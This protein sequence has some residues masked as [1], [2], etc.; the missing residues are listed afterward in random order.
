MVTAALS[1]KER[2]IAD[3]AEFERN[4]IWA[5][6]N[7]D[8]LQEYLDQYIAVLDQKM[9]GFSDDPNELYRRFGDRRDVHISWVGPPDLLWVL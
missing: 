1:A 5:S 2:L 3:L 8:R 9:V 6:E 7:R 4:A